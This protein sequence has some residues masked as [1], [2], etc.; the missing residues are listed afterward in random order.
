M[1]TL[2][3]T[4]RDARL[5]KKVGLSEAAAATRIKIQTLE[6]LESDNYSSIPAPVYGKGFV[7]M[8][9]EYLELDP[10][11]CVEEY[12]TQTGGAR[13]G[14]PQEVVAAQITVLDDEPKES[15]APSPES[16]PTPEPESDS[17]PKRHLTEEP[18]PVVGATAMERL[19]ALV[20][21]EPLKA[22]VAGLGIVAIAVFVLSGIGR[23][24]P[25]SERAAGRSGHAGG[26]PV[27]VPYEPPDPYLDVTP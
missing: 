10:R 23:C 19:V 13:S 12:V 6:G 5:K 2:G 3:D 15:A 8:Y 9:A 25:H 20:A 11:K 14:I 4:F 18:G 16:R 26:P 1:S 7:R 24:V 21:A 27:R 17:A 22:M